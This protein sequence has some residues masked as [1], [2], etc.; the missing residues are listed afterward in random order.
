[1]SPKLFNLAFKKIIRDISENLEMGVNENDVVKV[2]EKLI[3]SGHR[4][5]FVIN[6]NKSKHLMTRHVVKKAVLKVGS[7]SCDQRI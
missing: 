4:T 3:E 2:I 7:Y 1:M 5:N 6:V